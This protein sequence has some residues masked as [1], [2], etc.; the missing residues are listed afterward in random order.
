MSSALRH[1]EHLAELVRNADRSLDAMPLRPDG[2][3]QT[4]RLSLDALTGAARDRLSQGFRHL[5]EDEFPTLYC[6]WGKARVGSTAL[7]NLFGLAGL[8]AYYQPVKAIARHVL[9]G[10]TAPPWMPP[11]RRVQPHIFIKDVAGP[12]VLAE[13]LFI[14][15]QA[16][17]EAGYP[18][19]K[20][21][22]IVLDREPANSLASWLNKW[23]DR[24]AQDVLVRNYV[25]AALNVNCVESYAR[26]Q[27]VPITHYVYEASK[28]PVG[29]TRAL[30]AR[31][32][33]S[34]RFH[35]TAVTD[36]KET[37]Q[38]DSASARIIYPDEPAIYHVPGL[39][40]SG[41]GYKYRHRSTAALSGAQL[42]LLERT[43]V[44]GVY[45]AAAEGC[46]RD[47]GLDAATSASLFG[48]DFARDLRKTSSVASG[49]RH[50]RPA[51]PDRSP[52][53]GG[54]AATLSQIAPHQ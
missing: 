48:S 20:L 32:G 15:L 47:L 42:D 45:R 22:L 5:G 16:L 14:P 40:G 3:Y 6:A 51:T 49:T 18:V 50:G 38:L 31:L 4:R 35:E 39:H 12:Y 53:A 33:L 27:G 28:D 30:F 21:H 54:R 9:T 37:G 26:R 17:I 44:Q 10:G 46:A 34:D 24:V 8:P 11:S 41:A 1:L 29:S 43:G 19:S 23:S 7:V 52:T 2:R 36:W 13:C 25:I